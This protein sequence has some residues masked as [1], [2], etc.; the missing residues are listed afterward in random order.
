MFRFLNE[1]QVQVKSSQSFGR[2]RSNHNF[3][4]AKLS[5]IFME[6]ITDIISTSDIYSQVEGCG[7]EITKVLFFLDSSNFVFICGKKVLLEDIIIYGYYER[8]NFHL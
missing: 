4:S 5:K 7:L 2:K 1:A 3:R 8:C 6:K